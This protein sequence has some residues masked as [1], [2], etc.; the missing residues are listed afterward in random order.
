MDYKDLMKRAC[1]IALESGCVRAKVG[2][3]IAKD[4][5][6]LVEAYNRV[7]PTND[8]C[9]KHGCLRDKLGLSMGREAEKCRSIHSEAR[10]ISKAAFKGINIKGVDVYVSFSPCMNCAKL[11]WSA[12]IKRVF[13]CDKHSSLASLKF[14]EGMGV[15]CERI[16]L[17]GLEVSDRLRDTDGQ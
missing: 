10:A 7:L 4:G 8:F 9:Q 3:V 12:G 11:L 5:K 15:K 6:I 14:L 1:A 13:Y 16:E 17:E 2:T